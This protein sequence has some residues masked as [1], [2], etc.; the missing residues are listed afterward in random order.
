MMLSYL[1]SS[2]PASFIEK[3]GGSWYSTVAALIILVAIGAVGYAVVT[4]P[5]VFHS[6][7]KVMG[8]L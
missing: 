1:T 2:E 5:H 6:R 3:A 8:M 4:G 7:S